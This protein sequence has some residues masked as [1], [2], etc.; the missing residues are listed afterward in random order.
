[1]LKQTVLIIIWPLLFI[2]EQVNAS[3]LA[4]VIDDIGYHKKEDNQIL[5][6]PLAISIAILP[7]SPH[8]K[9][10]A[11]KA[12]QQGREILIHMP[13]KPINHQPLEKNTLTP[14]MS[15]TEIER[16][17]ITAIK[18][19]PHA[20]GMNNHMGSAMT[21]NLTFMLNVM[22]ILSRYN[23]YFLDS[24]TIANTKVNEAAKVFTLPTL[25][26]NIFLDDTKTKTQIRKQ[27]IYAISF[28]RKNGSSVIIA[29]PYFSTI[30]VLQQILFELPTDIE[31][32]TISTLLNNKIKDKL[33]N[34]TLR[35]NLKKVKIQF[36]KPQ[37]II[38]SYSKILLIKNIISC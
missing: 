11:K 4:I 8:G 13:M 12:F 24:V 38:L 14:E 23:L 1:M 22:R 27:F 29:H 37:K 33:T 31:L 25:R 30:N 6:L 19:V 21:T 35:Q 2:S 15:I 36:F 10:M 18:Q 3:K 5:A 28:A 9:E 20:K 16:N 17:I 7:D 34:Q 26:R 32:V